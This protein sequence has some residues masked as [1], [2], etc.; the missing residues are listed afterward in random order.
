MFAKILFTMIYYW[1]QPM[2]GSYPTQ[3]EK[4]IMTNQTTLSAS[5][6]PAVPAAKSS[7]RRLLLGCSALFIVVGCLACG[8]LGVLVTRVNGEL[9]AGLAALG[10][11][12]CD[13]AVAHFDTVNNSTWSTEENKASARQGMAL[14]QRYLELVT[15]QST[16]P[17][18]ALLGYDDLIR[19][20]GASPLIPVIEQQARTVFAAEPA[21][22]VNKT[23]CQRL[24]SYVER[25][26]ITDLN[27]NLPHYYQECGQVFTAAAAYGEAIAMY[28]RFI[29]AYPAH[30]ALEEVE[31]SLAKASVAEARQAG[32]GIIA[33]PQSTGG[34]GSGPALVIIQ[35]DSPEKLS[36]VF[37][38]PEARF[39]TIEACATCV[40]FT[41]SPEFCPEEGPIGEFELPAGV[42]E[43]VVKSISDDG[44]TPFTG[45]WE[46]VPGDEY[47]SC[48]F[49]VKR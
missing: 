33:P 16:D 32:A 8:V 41:S 3:Q 18:L 44:I 47:Y 49:L 42:Y 38:G 22:I 13:T 19:D 17:G 20:N 14:C 43:V 6:T 23:V 45:T 35:N 1:P 30:P 28:E 31:K 4:L 36:L 40:D 26:W 34:S 5:D 25:N 27:N 46:L 11:G 48:F 7:S 39:E 10:S 21:R 2:A 15:T 37:S 12:D 24:D 29:A 9:D